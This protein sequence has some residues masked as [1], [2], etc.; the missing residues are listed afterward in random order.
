[1]WAKHNPF[2][3]N[4]V[5]P[6]YLFAGRAAQ[7]L[8]ILKKMSETR[9]G[10]PSSFFLFGERGIG[11]TALAKLISS[12]SSKGN[13]QLYALRF[14]TAY[15]AAAPRQSFGSVLEAALNDLTDSMP[16]AW[17]QDI[18]QRLGRMWQN[19]KFS[20]GAFGVEV[21]TQPAERKQTVLRDEVVSILSNVVRTLKESPEPRDGVLIVIDEIQNIAD[22]EVAASMLR[23]ILAALDFKGLG[24]V[25][26]LLVGLEKAYE[27]F[28]QGDASA[29]R[30]FDPIALSAMP[31]Q[32]A[33]E[34]L[35][36]GFADVGM[37]WN[38]TFLEQ[39]IHLTGG[40]P[41]SIQ[42]LGHHLVNGDVDGRI[43]PDDW[44][45]AVNRTTSELRDKEFAAMYN[46]KRS[47][48]GHEKIMN[49]LALFGPIEKKELA[50][51]CKRAYGLI[52]PYQ[53]LG[54]LEKR[55]S[56]KNLP[57]GRLDLH[58]AFFRGAIL[59]GL[60]PSIGP[61]SPLDQMWKEHLR[62]WEKRAGE[63]ILAAPRPNG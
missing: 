26:F 53:Y 54:A 38:Q 55:G 42:V 32:E 58:S 24:N 25:S 41:H 4:G 47:A 37:Q 19:G 61:G 29:R 2:N 59:F 3:P 60:I 20:I 13:K 56:I 27:A 10:R 16:G 48:A 49:I 5:V 52:N 7:S 45:A 18:G 34:I 6:D 43:E 8:L 14:V 62:A 11:K 57:D 21:A 30:D 40:Y 44:D 9:Q 12:I 22:V 1:M 36:K 39:K 46:F 28:V 51:K 35:T 17:L 50:Q 63:E 31:P 15:Y 23:G 33:V